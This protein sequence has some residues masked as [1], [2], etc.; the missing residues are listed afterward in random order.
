MSLVLDFSAGIPVVVL[1]VIPATS[2]RSGSRSCC[3]TTASARSARAAKSR[4]PASTRGPSA[5]PPSRRD[6]ARGGASRAA[7]ELRAA[8][9]ERRLR[10]RLAAAAAPARAP[11]L[12]PRAAI[13]PPALWAAS[14]RSPPWASAAGRPSLAFFVLLAFVLCPRARRG[15]TPAAFA[16]GLG[17]FQAAS[18]IPILAAANAWFGRC[19][20]RALGALAASGFV[21]WTLLGLAGGSGGSFYLELMEGMGFSPR[22]AGPPAPGGFAIPYATSLVLPALAAVGVPLAYGA[23]C[24]M[25][26]QPAGRRC[27]CWCT[28][29]IA[30]FGVN[31]AATCPS[32]WVVLLF[33]SLGLLRLRGRAGALLAPCHAR[34][35]AR[36]LA[37]G[38]AALSP[39]RRGR[40]ALPARRRRDAAPLDL[41]FAALC[42]AGGPGAPAE[43]AR[44]RPPD[45]GSGWPRWRW[46]RR[47]SWWARR[48][49]RGAGDIHGASYA[50]VVLADW[51]RAELL[52]DRA[53]RRALAQPPAPRRA[54][55]ASD[56]QLREDAGRDA[57]TLARWMRDNGFTTS[58]TPTA[59]PLRNPAAGYYHRRCGRRRRS[60]PGAAGAGLRASRP[61]AC[62]RVESQRPGLRLRPD[63][64][65]CARAV[66]RRDPEAERALAYLQM[67]SPMLVQ[68]CSCCSMV[69]ALFWIPHQPAQ[70][71]RDRARLRGHLPR[72]PRATTC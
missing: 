7:P 24:A 27:T 30:I 40:P 72:S 3:Q 49:A 60:V 52:P 50:S 28:V 4:P 69:L 1:C 19:G 57:R 25:A 10:A 12:G 58:R 71:T 17:R 55:A 53:H 61:C 46:W 65:R 67:R 14:V 43:P 37:A 56:L 18:V 36:A 31:K 8:L 13:L 42:S 21:G 44:R 45:S 32:V 41:G 66:H 5:C 68:T 2:P 16:V 26:E 33:F 23:F 47:W 70:P 62:L 59:S 63:G 51:L 34:R 6:R 20:A 35:G 64:L 15:S 9:L 48:A 54:R 29:V 39:Q 11:L 38:D 22:P